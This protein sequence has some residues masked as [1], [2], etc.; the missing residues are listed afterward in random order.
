MATFYVSPTG[1]NANAGTLTAPFLTI[2]KGV[3]VCVAGDTLLVRAST[4]VESLQ[5]FS[6][7]TNLGGSTW[8]N[9]VRI[10]AYPGSG[11]VEAVWMKPSTSAEQVLRF[12]LSQKYF[13]FDGINLDGAN[14]KYDVVKIDWGGAPNYAHHIRIKNATIKS[15]HANKGAFY[16]AIIATAI[17]NFPS[18]GS[19]EFQKLTITGHGWE[20]HDQVFY[21]QSRDNLIENCDVSDFAAGG[22]EPYNAIAGDTEVT[23][24]IIRNNYFHDSAQTATTL[25]TGHRGITVA[26]KRNQIYNNVITRLAGNGTYPQNENALW[27]WGSSNL[28]AN[29]TVIYVNGGGI[30]IGSQDAGQAIGNTVRNNIAYGSSGST[31]GNFQLRNSSGT[32][33][34]H[35]LFGT[36]PRV[37][38]TADFHLTAVSAAIDTGVT[39]S[40]VTTDHDGIA[41]PQGAAYDLGAYE[42]VSS[43][44]TGL[45]TIHYPACGPSVNVH[46]SQGW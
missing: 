31:V 35:N 32:I 11:T 21:L 2:N 40:Q 24:N 43:A 7:F 38:S 8:S 26:G 44:S 22:C 13:E 46:V 37:V 28:V 3:S 16:Q 6:G 33:Q 23:G 10:A 25:V 39:I 19:N 12:G 20:S 5:Y 15:V 30:V 18:I 27:I 41:R 36:D 29:N 34:D 14:V 42:Y 1:N 4:Y 17:D 45:I 9:T